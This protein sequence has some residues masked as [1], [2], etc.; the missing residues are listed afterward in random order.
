M[1]LKHRSSSQINHWFPYELLTPQRSSQLA[2][3]HLATN[4]LN[5]NPLFFTFN[6]FFQKQT[7]S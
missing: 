7:S 6:L 2:D 1:D 5:H 3:S 4:T